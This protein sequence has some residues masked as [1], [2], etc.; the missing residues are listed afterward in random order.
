MSSPASVT[1][2][3]LIK[4]QWPVHERTTTTEGFY[5]V[6]AKNKPTNWNA[7]KHCRK[8]IFGPEF[9]VGRDPEFSKRFLYLHTSTEMTTSALASFIGEHTCEM[10]HDIPEMR[11]FAFPPDGGTKGQ[12]VLHFE[13]GFVGC[14][15]LIGAVTNFSGA[16]KEGKQNLDSLFL[17]LQ[18]VYKKHDA[19]VDYY[20][21]LEPT[22]RHVR[23]SVL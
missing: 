8:H 17:L 5:F 20:E 12:L 4:R 18:E 2:L 10:A 21:S 6:A 1:T 23:M 3:S 7:P 16:G 9:S 22:P 19:K 11:I 14:N 13:I 15:L